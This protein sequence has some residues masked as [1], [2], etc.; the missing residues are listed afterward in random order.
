M[1]GEQVQKLV[2]RFKNKTLPKS[3][4]THDAHIVVAFWYNWNYNFNEALQLVKDNIISY[5]NEVGTKNSDTSGYH[6]SLTKFWMILAKNHL[7]MNEFESLEGAISSFLKNISSA[8]DTALLYYSKEV[9]FSKK[10]RKKWVNGDL[11]QIE[12]LY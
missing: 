12:L 6:E 8:R 5:N 10:A 2:L 4:W 11:M 1:T 3:E 7:L 9:L